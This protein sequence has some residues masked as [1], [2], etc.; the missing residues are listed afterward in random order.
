M[1]MLLQGTTTTA[2]AAATYTTT[3]MIHHSPLVLHQPHC[4]I[5]GGRHWFCN[6]TTASQ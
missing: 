5:D 6:D 2:A 4:M 3:T 1:M